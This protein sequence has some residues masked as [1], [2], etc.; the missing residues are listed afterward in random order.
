MRSSFTGLT[1]HTWFTCLDVAGPDLTNLLLMS[2]LLAP[3]GATHCVK[4]SARASDPPAVG[5]QLTQA[6]SNTSTRQSS[7][8]P[9]ALFDG[10]QAAAPGPT[11]DGATGAAGNAA[12]QAASGSDALVL[13]NTLLSSSKNEFET[14]EAPDCHHGSGWHACLRCLS[15]QSGTVLCR[16]MRLWPPSMAV[17]RT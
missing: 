13:L 7:G 16:Y 5:A 4:V 14:G 15:C 3:T 12:Q 10:G 17:L 6:A 2:W 11:A 1:W 9:A 8:T